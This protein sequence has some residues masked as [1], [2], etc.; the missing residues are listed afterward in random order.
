MKI[1]FGSATVKDNETSLSKAN[2]ADLNNVLQPLTKVEK[3]GRAHEI[4]PS[5]RNS[6][7]QAKNQV[8]IEQTQQHGLTHQL[9]SPK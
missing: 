3:A 5:L 8:N 7:Y 2:I 1:K 9:G 6:A 4:I